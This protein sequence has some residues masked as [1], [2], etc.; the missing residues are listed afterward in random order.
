MYDRRDNTTLY[1]QMIYTG[2][3]GS[4]K[5]E[6]LEL[7][8]AIVTTFDMWKKMYPDSQVAVSGTGLNIYPQWQSDRYA[9]EEVYGFYPYGDYRTNQWQF[10]AP[11][12]TNQPDLLNHLPKE[13]VTGI[14]IE[15]DL[16]AYP[17]ADMFPSAVIND[18]VGRQPLLI[19]FHSVSQTSMPFSRVVDGRTL[20]FYQVESAGELP[21]EFR[22]VETNT[23][24]DLLGRGVEGPLKDRQLEQLPAYN[25]MWFAWATYWPET[26]VWEPGEGVIDEPPITAVLEPEDDGTPQDF[27]LGQNFP[28]PFNPQTRI[29]FTLP[30]DGQTSLSIY[31]VT[32][33]RVRSLADGFHRAGLYLV[34]WDGTDEAGRAVASG[35]YH[36]RL[37][38]REAGVTETRT[39]TLTR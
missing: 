2:I 13:M 7:L 31:N 29:Q 4:F 15:D 23:T 20:S 38:M 35:T 10:I 9:S 28:N 6:Q 34:T 36:Y 3:N 17:F 32:G 18:E 1:P 26:S 14:C 5:G 11:V 8:P 39:M 24:W 22:D 16:R 37:T 25:S 21:V 33:Q 12:T 30:A 27:A 19:V